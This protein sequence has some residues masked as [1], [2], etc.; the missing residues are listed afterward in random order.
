MPHLWHTSARCWHS[1]LISLWT[2]PKK[3][4]KTAMCLTPGSLKWKDE[5]KPKI[6]SLKWNI[7]RWQKTASN[8]PLRG[9]VGRSSATCRRV[10]ACHWLDTPSIVS[11]LWPGPCPSWSGSTEAWLRT[12]KHP[13][14]KYLTGTRMADF[15]GAELSHK[16][17]DSSNQGKS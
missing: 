11:P 6:K 2:A 14:V 9:A 7:G 4:K 8:L 17:F 5:L 12:Q 13:P 10:W 1:P 3:E 15:E 16:I